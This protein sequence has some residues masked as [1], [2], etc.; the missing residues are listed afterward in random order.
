MNGRVSPDKTEKKKS[1][2]NNGKIQNHYHSLE[3]SSD[4]YTSDS[5]HRMVKFRKEA[6][7]TIVRLSIDT[8]TE[9]NTPVGSGKFWFED[10]YEWKLLA[11]FGICGLLKILAM[12]QM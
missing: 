11:S 7:S 8:L 10:R 3:F 1:L 12:K 4:Y 2:N 5:C 9:V 6:S